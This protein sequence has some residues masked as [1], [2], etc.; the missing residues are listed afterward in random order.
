METS[1]HSARTVI[2]YPALWPCVALLAK[3]VGCKYSSQHE[4]LNQRGMQTI[5]DLARNDAL[6]LLTERQIAEIGPIPSEPVILDKMDKTIASCANAACDISSNPQES[7]HTHTH[8][9]SHD[10]D[11][12]H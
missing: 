12:R 1:Q 4:F 6:S 5:I 2:L 3:V 10:H 7:P 8:D 11:H 9:D